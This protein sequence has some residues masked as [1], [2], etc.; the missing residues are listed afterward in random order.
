MAT[1]DLLQNHPAAEVTHLLL[2]VPLLLLLLLLPSRSPFRQAAR[3]SCPA[4]T[5]PQW[6]WE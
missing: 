1:V 6:E 5:F 2:F 4:K 3:V